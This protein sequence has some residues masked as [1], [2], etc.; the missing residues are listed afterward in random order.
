M[1]EPVTGLQNMPMDSLQNFKSFIFS[2][3]KERTNVS[4]VMIVN[5]KIPTRQKQITTAEKHFVKWK[6]F[7]FPL[8]A[9]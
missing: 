2:K 6:L 7:W 5:Q 3:L 8:G 4:K 1:P 9:L